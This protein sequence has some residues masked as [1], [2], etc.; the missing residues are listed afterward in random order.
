M[1]AFVA[2]GL[3]R[4]RGNEWAHASAAPIV[5]APPRVV[6]RDESSCQLPL[7]LLLFLSS[8]RARRQPPPPGVV[9]VRATHH[10]RGSNGF[11][12][13]RR[14]Q[15]RRQQCASGAAAGLDRRQPAAKRGQA[16]QCLPKQT[17]TRLA[18]AD[19]AAGRLGPPARSK[20]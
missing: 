1:C 17:G 12:G 5:E 19:D 14:R 15:W 4:N 10:W 7:L 13:S 11:S 16:L 6:V 2:F 18:A 3:L 20:L 9:C 8:D